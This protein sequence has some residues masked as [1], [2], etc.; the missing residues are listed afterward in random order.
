MVKGNQKE[1]KKFYVGLTNVKI[2]AINPNRNELNKLLGREDKDED[3]EID[4]LSEYEDKKRVRINIWLRDQ[5]NDNLYNHSFNILDE[6]RLN[7]TGDKYQYINSTCTT[8]WI[9]DE[10]NLPSWF[11]NFED[12]QTKEVLGSKKYRKA[13]QGEDELVTIVRSWL[14]KLNWNHQDTE[15]EI[16]TKKLLS[17][18]FKELQSQI[19]GDY[20]TS[21]TVLLGVKTV[22]PKEGEEG[23]NKQYQS[24]YTKTI[25]PSSFM[26]FINNNFT[27]PNERTTKIWNKFKLEISGD[28]GP[29]FYYELEVISEYNKAKDLA[30][31]SLKKVEI[32]DEDSTY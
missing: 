3:K 24:I 14:G 29:D 17:G 10:D 32:V 4:Y 21:F 9:D 1:T 2:V 12:F 16:N 31:T 28:Y 6:E 8:T 20:D 18:N 19:D 11:I 25:L 15:V 13:L 23:E 22:E 5:T 27:F 26:K 30:A 7:K